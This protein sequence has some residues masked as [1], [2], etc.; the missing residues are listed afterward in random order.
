MYYSTHLFR[1]VQ[2]FIYGYYV[3]CNAHAVHSTLQAYLS[4]LYHT[5]PVLKRP[6]SVFCMKIELLIKVAKIAMYSPRK[7]YV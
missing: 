1:S 6:F 7:I 2:N 3:R 4:I 5:L